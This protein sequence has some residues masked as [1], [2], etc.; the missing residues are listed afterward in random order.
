MRLS[1]LIHYSAFVSLLSDSEPEDV[2][3]QQA[4]NCEQ[5]HQKVTVALVI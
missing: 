1:I 2:G 3:L 5:F 4:I